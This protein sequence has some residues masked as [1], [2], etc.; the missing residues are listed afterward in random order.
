MYTSQS[1]TFIGRGSCFNVDYGCCSAYF[2]NYK[3]NKMFLID[4][5]GDVFRKIIKNKEKR[6]F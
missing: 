2:K 4:C 3:R 1:L 6:N 5:G